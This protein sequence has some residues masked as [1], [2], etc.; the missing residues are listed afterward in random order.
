MPLGTI[1]RS[2]SRARSWSLTAAITITLGVGAL[3]LTFGVVNAALFR[4]P[5]FAEADEI[6]LLYLQRNPSGEA[7]R[8]ER[9]S[10]PRFELFAETQ[11]SF[12]R[13]A[14]YSPGSVTL[15][16]TGSALNSI[17]TPCSVKTCCARTT[18]N[19]TV[20]SNSTPIKIDLWNTWFIV[21]HLI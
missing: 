5:P 12:E 21:V 1:G 9:W 13:V 2:L 20:T 14:S 7:P 18:P 8:R 4:P 10:F 6:A 16:G 15:S 11:Q 17:D 19:C 3:T